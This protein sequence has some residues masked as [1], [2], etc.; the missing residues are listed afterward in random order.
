[1]HAEKGATDGVAPLL[2]Q[3]NTSPTSLPLLLCDELPEGYCP[4]MRM[5]AMCE[6]YVC[7]CWFKL[8]HLVWTKLTVGM[9]TLVWLVLGKE[10]GST[11]R[12]LVLS[13]CSSLSAWCPG[14][15]CRGGAL[16]SFSFGFPASFSF[17]LSFLLLPPSLSFLWMRNGGAVR[18]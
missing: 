4:M 15:H 10:D 9:V 7:M 11:G 2:T 17:P 12:V 1:M 5:D 13:S 18:Q 6:L 8:S 3:G 16:A 14:G